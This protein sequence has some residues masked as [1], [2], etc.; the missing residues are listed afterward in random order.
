MRLTLWFL[1]SSHRIK[2]SPNNDVSWEV[3]YSRANSVLQKAH[4]NSTVPLLQQLQPDFGANDNWWDVQQGRVS[5]SISGTSKSSSVQSEIDGNYRC[6]INLERTQGC[7]A[8]A[9]FMTNPFTW[10]STTDVRMEAAPE[11]ESHSLNV[12]RE[13]I[14]NY[15]RMYVRAR[16]IGTV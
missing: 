5:S 9:Y 10:P 8:V 12:A 6:H 3:Q 1:L 7:G 16:V 14:Q 4:K 11:E 2:K 13:N 15:I